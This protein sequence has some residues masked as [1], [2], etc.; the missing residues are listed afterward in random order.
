MKQS[1]ST[2]HNSVLTLVLPLLYITFYQDD[3]SVSNCLVP[4]NGLGRVQFLKDATH[5]VEKDG[6]HK[7]T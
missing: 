1:I 5:E 3:I 6:A 4:S 7:L 2:S